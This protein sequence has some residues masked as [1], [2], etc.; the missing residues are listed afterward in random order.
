MPISTQQ[1]GVADAIDKEIQRPFCSNPGVQLPDGSGRG[2]AG[3][4][5]G[6]L[7]MFL[8]LSVEL[9]K[10]FFLKKDLAADAEFFRQVPARN[11]LE[12]QRD[13][14]HCFQLRCDVLTGKAVASG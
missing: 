2:V 6:G 14:R 11:R 3:V 7:A 13:G 12:P 5:K 8:P 4:G 10:S 9:E 1:T